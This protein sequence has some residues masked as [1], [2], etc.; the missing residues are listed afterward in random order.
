[1]NSRVLLGALSLLLLGGGLIYNLGVIASDHV[2]GVFEGSY[3]VDGKVFLLSGE[4]RAINTPINKTL[5]VVQ[6]KAFVNGT[7]VFQYKAVQGEVVTA[8]MVSG[9]FVVH[10]LDGP[11]QIIVG[12]YKELGRGW[13]YVDGTAIILGRAEIYR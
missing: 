3:A 2:V 9:K 8:S 4:V 7:I 12:Q 5:Y 6:G 1:M 10:V 13:Y 11:I